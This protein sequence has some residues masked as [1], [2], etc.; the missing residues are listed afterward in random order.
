MRV[1]G[2][3]LLAAL[4]LPAALAKAPEISGIEVLQYGIFTA[5]VP[6]AP[7]TAPQAA[8]QAAQ[9]PLPKTAPQPA[10]QPAGQAAQPS[11]PQSAAPAIPSTQESGLH[12]V[13][14]TRTIP[15]QK[16]VQFGFQYIV[17]GRPKFAKATLHFVVIYP[18]PGVMKP[19]A[20][21]PILRDEYNQAVSID[22][23]G[24]ID[25]YQIQN[26]WE[27]APGDWT[28]EIWNGNAKLASE[29]FTLVKQ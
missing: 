7:Q 24:D 6:A 25:G 17:R 8:P 29:T 13:T 19:G 14:Q 1:L 20:T 5:A 10:Q 12:L 3:I 28:L 16:G 4:A 15:M 23:E 11:A 22:T 2:T 21:S 27:M 9:Q 18:A 26:D